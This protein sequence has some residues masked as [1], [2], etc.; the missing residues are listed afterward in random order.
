MSWVLFCRPLCEPLFFS[1]NP[2][3]GEKVIKGS[4]A[5]PWLEE[6][7]S[8]RFFKMCSAHRDGPRSECNLYCLNCTTHSSAFCF[9][10]RSSNHKDHLVIQIRRSSYHDVVRV[11]EIEKVLDISGVQT[12]VI[13]SAKVVFLNERPHGSSHGSSAFKLQTS[14]SSSN[15]HNLICEICGRTLLDPFRYCSLGCKLVGVKKNGDANYYV[16]GNEK[17]GVGIRRD[18]RR[19]KRLVVSKEEDDDE[20]EEKGGIII[21]QS[22]DGINN[23]NHIHDHDHYSNSSSRRRKGTP[24]RAPLGAP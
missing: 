24:H 18:Y 15:S 13:N 4:L 8:T 9:Y 5:P 19:A 2:T 21:I 1:P 11:G 3:E 22:R 20:E 6:L 16:I 17:N 7:L 23:N 14:S 10:C 12:Y